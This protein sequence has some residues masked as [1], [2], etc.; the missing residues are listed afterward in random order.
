MDLG[1][2]GSLECV[3]AD[4]GDHCFLCKGVHEFRIFLVFLLSDKNMGE[5]RCLCQFFEI[6][7]VVYAL[8]FY[9]ET[10]HEIFYHGIV[11]FPDMGILEFLETKISSE[12]QSFRIPDAHAVIIADDFLGNTDTDCRASLRFTFDRE[13]AVQAPDEAVRDGKTEAEA[14]RRSG[15]SRVCLIEALKYHFQFGTAHADSCISYFEEQINSVV[16]FLRCDVDIDA[17]LFRI[18]ES[19][20]D[21]MAEYFFD[22]SYIGPHGG[23]D[24]G[25][26]VDDELQIRSLKR[27]DL[28]YGVMQQ[29]SD[30]IVFFIYRKR[31]HV[32]LGIVQNIADLLPDF[33]PGFHDGQKISLYIL[34]IDLFGADP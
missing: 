30:H 34:V 20:V 11:K 12:T 7:H 24:P 22:F 27:S 28:S 32:D 23:R 17:A 1:V 2:I 21:Q 14:V 15:L 19:V 31:A 29:R 3:I 18:L 6:G 33:L 13:E 4:H 26:H 16:P 10:Q 8:H 9:T 5:I 25:I